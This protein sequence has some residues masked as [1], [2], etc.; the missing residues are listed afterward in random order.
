MKCDA[1]KDVKE[2]EIKDIP[3]PS[4]DHENV[5]IEVKKCGICG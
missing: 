2:F 5:V 1:I 4:V 3:Q